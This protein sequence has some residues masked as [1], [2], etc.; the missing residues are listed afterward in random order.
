ML[1]G[2]KRVAVALSGGKDSVALL[3]AMQR[4]GW[5]MDFEVTAMHFDLGMGEYSEA[6]LR[7]VEGL[8]REPGIAA[9]SGAH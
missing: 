4:L 2:A 6:N 5:V 3:L 1:Q 8:T 7:M 9:A